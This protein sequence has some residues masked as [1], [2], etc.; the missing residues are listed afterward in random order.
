MRRTP[1][2][3]APGAR[4]SGR[5][6]CPG[7]L[8]TPASP[9]SRVP[10]ANSPLRH[11]SQRRARKR[12]LSV[13]R[14]SLRRVE[15]AL[16]YRLRTNRSRAWSSRSLQRSAK[17]SPRRSPERIAS[18]TIVLAAAAA[19]RVALRPVVDNAHFGR[20]FLRS[21]VPRLAQG[22]RAI[23][24]HFT[25]VRRTALEHVVDVVD[26]LGR[27]TGRVKIGHV[28]LNLLTRDRR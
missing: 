15:H 5:W 21:E 22:S 24:P 16:V 20:T 1:R 7:S 27:I 4:C 25:A 28:W 9:G 10:G 23:C 12:N 6:A 26:R 8:R 13:R 11:R 17:S 2:R 19:R 3:R 18:P 14:L